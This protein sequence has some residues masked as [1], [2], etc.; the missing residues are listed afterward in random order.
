MGQAL[1]QALLLGRLEGLPEEVIFLYARTGMIHLFSA[2][3]FHMAAALQLS[4]ACQWILQKF[5]KRLPWLEFLLAISFMAFLGYATDWS[6]PMVR[7]FAFSSILALARLWEIRASRDWVFLLSLLCSAL[8]GRG[9]LLS[10]FL[11]ALGMAGILYV[12]P[13]NLWTLALAPWAATLPLTIWHFHLFSLSAPLWN[14]LLGTLISWTVLPLALLQLFLQT[15]GLGSAYLAAACNGLMVF[16]T[17]VLEEGDAW[18]GGSYWVN[19]LPWIICSGLFLAGLYKKRKVLWPCALVLPLLWPEPRLAMLDVGQG[20]ALFFRTA[21]GGRMLMD[22]G[23]PPRP[24]RV[25]RASQQLEKMGI[26]GI[27]HLLLS[28]LDLD[29]RG[30]LSSLLARHRVGT[31]WLREEVLPQAGN[32]LL[33]AEA[34]KVPIRFFPETPP[35]L[36]CWLA[37]FGSANDSSPLCLAD[38]KR[39]DRLLLTGDM[40]A[41]TENYFLSTLRPFPHARFLKVAH[42]G[43]KGSSLPTF[44]AAARAEWALVSAGRKNRYRHPAQETLTRLKQTGLRV[45]RTDLEGSVLFY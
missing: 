22:V 14:L 31:L 19:P 45:S 30:G 9:S 35:G 33:E 4:W 34:A 26:A 23:P 21:G 29:H 25:A 15:L 1:V 32:I 24:G 44:L 28:H 11:S 2:S 5:W 13:R 7:A 20:D 41:T 36:Q 42:H 43:S 16:F 18:L 10:F 37:P 8:L 12:Q 27:D 3:G 17:S 38:L 6:S 40:S 39:G